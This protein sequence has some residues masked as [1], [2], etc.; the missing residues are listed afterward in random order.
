MGLYMNYTYIFFKS[1]LVRALFFND[2][3]LL[4]F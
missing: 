2:K 1:I 3:T 4:Q